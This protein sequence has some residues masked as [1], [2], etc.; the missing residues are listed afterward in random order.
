MQQLLTGKIRFPGFVGEWKKR[1]IKQMGKVVSG[2]TPD[3]LT[4]EYWNGDILWMTPTDVTALRTRFINN[5]NRKITQEGIKNSSA[6]IIP[7]GS[8]LVCTRATI[9]VMS[10]STTDIT[11][12]QGFKNLVPSSKFDVNFLY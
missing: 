7:S 2:G 4:S 8:L 12:N 6:T 10:I 11:T 3:T 5:T 9:G 1:A